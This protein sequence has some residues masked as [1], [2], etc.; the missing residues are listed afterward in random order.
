MA[1]VL[2]SIHDFYNHLFTTLK[3]MSRDN[4]FPSGEISRIFSWRSADGR[5]L[6]HRWI[7][8]ADT[9]T[10]E[11]ILHAVYVWPEVHGVAEAFRAENHHDFVQLSTGCAKHVLCLRGEQIYYSIRQKFRLLIGRRRIC[12]S[13]SFH[14]TGLAKRL[15]SATVNMGWT[16]W[17]WCIPTSTLRFSTY[18]TRWVHRFSLSLIFNEG[19][20]FSL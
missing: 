10:D 7:S 2:R 1:L 12:C 13:G 3:G 14:S 15:T 16:S 19:N 6:L 11:R 9:D 5:L 4:L 20:I 18:S 8:T 17:G